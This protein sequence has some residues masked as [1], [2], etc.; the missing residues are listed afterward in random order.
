MVSAAK[1]AMRNHHRTGK[2]WVIVEPRSNTMRTNIHQSRLPLCFDDA[3]A[4]IFTPASDRGLNK[5][6]V[7]DVH[8]VC[9]H[10]GSHAQV[11]PHAKAIIEYLSQHAEADDDILILSNGGF[12]NIHQQLLKTL[13]A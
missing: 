5:D 10:I 1:H 9:Q 6:E 13:Q 12:D 7:L 11:L 2:L 8:L 3:D 4:I